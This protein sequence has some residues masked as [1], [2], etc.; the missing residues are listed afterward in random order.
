MY[1]QSRLAMTPSLD[2]RSSGCRGEAQ[3][4]GVVSSSG[5]DNR[6]PSVCSIALGAEAPTRWDDLQARRSGVMTVDLTKT[7]RF[8]GAQM[9]MRPGNQLP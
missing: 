5:C 2:G 3:V 1:R 9:D 6:T 4:T 8:V 7:T